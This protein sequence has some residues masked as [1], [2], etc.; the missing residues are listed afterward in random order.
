MRE[1]PAVQRRLAEVTIDDAARE[2]RPDHTALLVAGEGLRGGLGDEASEQVLTAGEATARASLEGRNPVQLPH[3]GQWREA[4]RAFGAQPQRTRPSVEAAPRRLDPG[5]PRI[6][7]ITDARDAV[8]IAHQLPLG[9][10]D[11]DAECHPPPLVRA[12]GAEDV[13]VMAGGEPAVE[14]PGR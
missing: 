9:G 13:D 8:S 12:T 3:P 1:V 2:L 5:L 6:D 11:L 14:R 10:E 4:Y 7:R